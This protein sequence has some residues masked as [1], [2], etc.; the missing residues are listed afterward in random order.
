MKKYLL[1]IISFFF[2]NYSFCDTTKDSLHFNIQ[3][4][5]SYLDFNNLYFIASVNEQN[6]KIDLKLNFLL[7]N[8]ANKII[9]SEFNFEYKP[10]KHK[11]FNYIELYLSCLSFTYDSLS[12]VFTHNGIIKLSHQEH[13]NYSSQIFSKIRITDQHL[14]IF[15]RSNKNNW[16]YF[17]FHKNR[18][19]TI[20]SIPNYNKIVIQ[21]AKRTRKCYR[22]QIST[23]FRVNNFLGYH[24]NIMNN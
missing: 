4:V 10:K 14:T 11:N 18:L 22:Y 1:L 23:N 13:S 21:R 16:F 12:G 7:H 5:N 3:I 19:N 6:K 9:I 8:K 24:A 2:I 17:E 15:L 20:S